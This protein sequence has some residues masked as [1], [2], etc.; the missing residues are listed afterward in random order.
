M[1]RP[2]SYTP[3]IAAVISERI[4][5]GEGLNSICR[6]NGMPSKSVVMRWLDKETVEGQAFRDRYARARL[7]QADTLFDEALEIADDTAGDWVVVNG[8]KVPAKELVQR[9]RLRVDTRKWA[10]GKL[11]P[12][13][14]GD[15]LLHTDEHGTGPARIVI[16]IAGWQGAAPMALA[17][18]SPP[19]LEDGRTVPVSVEVVGDA[20]NS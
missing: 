19:S 11:S 17:P 4:A 9:A 14:Y 18:E 15:K 8:K 10:A 2:S 7:R 5:N 6:E 3:E 16:E 20:G 12:Q 13:K 1:G